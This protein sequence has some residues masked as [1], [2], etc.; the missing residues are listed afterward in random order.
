MPSFQSKIDIEIEIEKVQTYEIC[1][2]F[3]IFE[4]RCFVYLDEIYGVELI[5]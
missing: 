1:S 3:N 4:N 2:A 5:D